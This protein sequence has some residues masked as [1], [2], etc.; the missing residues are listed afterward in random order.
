MYVLVCL[1]ACL[2]ACLSVRSVARS[3]TW[4]VARSLVWGSLGLLLGG[5]WGHTEKDTGAVLHRFI[6]FDVSDVE[7]MLSMRR[8][9]P[10][11]PKLRSNEET[12]NK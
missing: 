12:E 5:L 4:G 1:S 7:Q 2:P 3:P 8:T 10:S 9:P 11:P 6:P